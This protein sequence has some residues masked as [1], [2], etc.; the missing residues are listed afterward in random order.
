[1]SKDVALKVNPY[2]HIPV[3]EERSAREAPTS[4]DQVRKHHLKIEKAITSI[5]VVLGFNTVFIGVVAYARVN[6]EL[7][8]AHL[9]FLPVVLLGL[10]SYGLWSCQSWARWPTVLFSFLLLST[11][12]YA[13]FLALYMLYSVLCSKSYVV[14]T[15]D[16]REIRRRTRHVVKTSALTWVMLF[17]IVATVVWLVFINVA[18]DAYG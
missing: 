16:Y 7:P 14:L 18:P 2:A 4:I 3:A 11:S 10:L 17:L 12:L 6:S 13:S 5:G 1:V 8:G 15:A 9:L